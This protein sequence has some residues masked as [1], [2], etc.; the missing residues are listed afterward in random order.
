METIEQQ[1]YVVIALINATYSQR[2]L[3]VTCRELVLQSAM[4]KIRGNIS[5]A[6]VIDHFRK[7]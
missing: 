4:G 5:G 1:R 6:L 7:F 2:R 3:P